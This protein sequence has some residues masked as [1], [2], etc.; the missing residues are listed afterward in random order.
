M[1]KFFCLKDRALF[2]AYHA[3]VYFDANTLAQA[4]HLCLAA[5][6]QFLLTMGRVHQKPVGP[7]PSWSCQLAFQSEEFATLIPWLNRHRAGLT[8]LIHPVTED[9]LKDHRDYAMWLGQSEKLDLSIFG[10]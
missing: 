7:H 1:F 4:E 10:G 5:S 9:D 6:E 3:H 8:V 2:T